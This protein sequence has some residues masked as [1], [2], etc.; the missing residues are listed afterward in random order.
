MP[1]CCGPWC[2]CLLVGVGGEEGGAGGWGGEGLEERCSARWCVGPMIDLARARRSR[3][4]PPG[5]CPSTS[6]T[7]HPPTT[8]RPTTSTS[9]T[10]RSR[11][12]GM[13]QAARDQRKRTRPHSSPSLLL[14]R[15]PI[16]VLAAAA[17]ASSRRVS[18][19]ATAFLLRHPTRPPARHPLL[20]ALYVPAVA[21]PASVVT[22]AGRGRGGGGKK[23]KDG[24]DKLSKGKKKGDLPSKDCVV[25]GRPFTW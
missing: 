10:R 25:C 14:L 4:S 22:A 12:G 11:E 2:C 21:R 7:S 19:R 23:N 5:V 8:H 20:P 17:T 3:S 6:C 13:K 9:R 1:C 15:L 24:E 16:M 18:P